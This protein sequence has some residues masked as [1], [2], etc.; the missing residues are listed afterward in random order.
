MTSSTLDIKETSPFLSFFAGTGFCSFSSE[1]EEEGA[2]ALGAQPSS[3]SILV[4]SSISS[5]SL[6]GR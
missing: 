1:E 5:E 6:G 2:G 3:L 4:T